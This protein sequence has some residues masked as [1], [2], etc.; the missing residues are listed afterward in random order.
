MTANDKIFPFFSVTMQR[1]EEPC[2]RDGFALLCFVTNLNV[3]WKLFRT[4][5]SKAGVKEHFNWLIHC[6]SVI[7]NFL[8]QY[9]ACKRTLPQMSPS[10]E[11]SGQSTLPLQILSGVRQTE[12]SLAHGY[13]GGLHTADSHDSSS[14]RSSQS[15][16]PSHTQLFVMH[17]PAGDEQMDTQIFKY[18]QAHEHL[19][20]S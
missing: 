18:S 12:L 4:Q 1:I 13:F 10:S 8:L 2:K 17:F 14:E 5:T 3:D 11:R 7:M 6:V 19:M 20:N 15:M 16:S 9:I